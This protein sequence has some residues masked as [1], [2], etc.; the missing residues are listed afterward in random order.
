MIN[1]EHRLKARLFPHG[2]CLS[3]S[4]DSDVT[5]RPLAFLQVSWKV[6]QTGE[7]ILG[8]DSGLMGLTL[9]L[10]IIFPLA[11]YSPRLNGEMTWFCKA[12]RDSLGSCQSVTEDHI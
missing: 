11:V 6:P 1:G 10:A 2:H 3:Y 7:Q 5:V 4:Q 12:L 9:T 8:T